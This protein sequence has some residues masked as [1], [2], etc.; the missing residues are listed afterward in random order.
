M[1]FYDQVI[2][3]EYLGVRSVY[4]VLLGVAIATLTLLCL[5]QRRLD[6]EV[7]WNF[8]GPLPGLVPGEHSSPL[9]SP[10]R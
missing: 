4:L 5:D 2:S 1:D 6:N 7:G 10:K 8:T 9:P 3:V